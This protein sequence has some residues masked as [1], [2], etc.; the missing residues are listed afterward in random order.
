LN[1]SQL[2]KYGPEAR[3]AFI[4]AVSAQAARLGITAHGITPAE[5]KGDIL[6]VAG[7]A[8]PRAMAPARNSLSER[9]KAHGFAQT[10]EA[11]AYT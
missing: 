2:S 6:L 4:A 7:H 10:M 8:F 1:T 3:R 9:I 5:V 11:I